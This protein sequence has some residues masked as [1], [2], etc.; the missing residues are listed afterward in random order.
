MVLTTLKKFVNQIIQNQNLTIDSVYL[1]GSLITGD[2]NE[3]SDID[4]YV[5]SDKIED[6]N[7]LKNKI[8]KKF[9]RDVFINTFSL[10]EFE[11]LLKEGLFIHR[12]RTKLF[13]YEFLTNSFKNIYGK[14]IVKE[15]YY[16]L[17]FYEDLD[18]EIL[19]NIYLFKYFSKKYLVNPNLAINQLKKY[20]KF[21]SK[22]YTIFYYKKFENYQTTL[23]TL[24]E[25]IKLPNLKNHNEILSFY[26][27]VFK[28]L[29]DELKKRYSNTQ[30]ALE[31]NNFIIEGYYKTKSSKKAIIY[32]NG[33][34]NPS[35]IEK[36]IKFF[37]SKNITFFNI[38]YPG[39][40]K[41]RGTLDYK[42]L[43]TNLKKLNTY[44]KEGK[45]YDLFRKEQINFNF[46]EVI[47]LGSSF[48]GT[49]SLHFPKSIAISPL[50]YFNKNKNII[51]D[52]NNKLKFFEGPI[53]IKNLEDFHFIEPHNA[54]SNYVI[55][56]INDNVIEH[57]ILK[58]FIK[59]NNL[60]SL[61]LNIGKHGYKLLNQY[62]LE[63]IVQK[64]KW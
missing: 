28:E 53:R 3:K 50:V 21:T 17:P 42:T 56:D 41:G 49:L 38:Y 52:L 32:L 18:Y 55:Y 31:H 60:Y 19:Q 43:I 34:P 16:Y 37:T 54:N 26:D 51:D 33:M 23:K 58:N 14:D 40:W 59:R 30:F 2:F 9:Q 24:D 12:E 45:F 48:G 57:N 39:Y 35:K 44:I 27:K 1:Y 29:E 6:V 7:L 64:L 8:E 11:F 36:Q 63:K 61:E 62:V 10:K 47:I 5:F 25:N 46:E 13:L 22:L 20:I 4:I 15:F